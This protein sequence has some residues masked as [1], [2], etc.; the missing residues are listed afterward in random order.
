M[1]NPFPPV[2]LELVGFDLYD[3]SNRLR[4]NPYKASAA[5]H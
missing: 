1:V 4:A 2:G 5:F 3:S